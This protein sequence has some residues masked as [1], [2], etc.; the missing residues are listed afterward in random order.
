MP[1]GGFGDA[2][3]RVYDMEKAGETAAGTTAQ[4]PGDEVLELSGHSGAVSGLD[5]S[6]DTDLL[7]SASS[8][9]TLRL[10]HLPL[11]ACLNSYR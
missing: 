9:G 2:S 10:W 7:F 4:E 3:I 1:A 11:V 5:F 8:D 6:P